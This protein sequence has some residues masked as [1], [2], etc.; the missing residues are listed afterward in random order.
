MGKDYKD[1]L[2]MMKTEFPMRGN[3]AN[4]EP[5]IQKCGKKRIFIKSFRENK[6]YDFILHDGHLMLMVIFMLV[7]H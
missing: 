3:L 7:M 6:Q 2:L 1:T 5:Q 4:K